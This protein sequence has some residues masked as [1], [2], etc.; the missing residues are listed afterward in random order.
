M[1]VGW[2][3]RFGF[4]RRYLYHTTHAME[5]RGRGG[6]DDLASG[7]SSREGEFDSGLGEGNW[8]RFVSVSV[9][10]RLKGSRARHQVRIYFVVR[11]M[12]RCPSSLANT[13]QLEHS[14]ILKYVH[15][16]RKAEANLDQT[17]R[18]PVPNESPLQRHHARAYH[19]PYP[20]FDRR[21]DRPSRIRPPR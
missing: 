21:G 20:I 15:Y 5:T 12:L 2:D 7:C 8:L 9:P 1:G 17:Q 4:S 3:F 19:R 10:G 13:W 16:Y 18:I 11:G 14:G 6:G